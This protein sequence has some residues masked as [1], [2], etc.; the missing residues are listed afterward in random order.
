MGPTKPDGLFPP[1]LIWLEVPDCTVE[2]PV[3]YPGAGQ[4]TPVPQVMFRS[5][6]IGLQVRKPKARAFETHAT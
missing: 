4:H 2:C 3:R 1:R 5:A 6:C